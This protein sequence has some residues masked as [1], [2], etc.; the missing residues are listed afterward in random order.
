MFLPFSAE[1]YHDETL[2]Q[3][4]GGGDPNAFESFLNLN[5]SEGEK[6]LKTVVEVTGVTDRSIYQAFNQSRESNHDFDVNNAIEW[7]LTNSEAVRAVTIPVESVPAVTI[8]DEAIPVSTMPDEPL[9]TDDD[10][11]DR[12]IPDLPRINIR[13]PENNEEIVTP[14]DHTDEQSLAPYNWNV[15]LKIPILD[16]SRDGG[17]LFRSPR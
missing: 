14:L 15:E 11:S 1:K 9:F 7:I 2:D 17:W 6:C 13:N 16:I 3:A 10:D 12:E 5:P 4:R 8:P